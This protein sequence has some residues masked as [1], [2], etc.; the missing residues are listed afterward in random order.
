MGDIILV[1]SYYYGSYAGQTWAAGA[2][3]HGAGCAVPNGGRSDDAAD[4]HHR[5]RDAERRRRQHA[6][7]GD[8]CHR[9]NSDHNPYVRITVSINS[10][11]KSSGHDG[12]NRPGLRGGD[13]GGAPEMGRHH[14][15]L[16]LHHQDRWQR[17]VRREELAGGEGDLDAGCVLSQ[18]TPTQFETSSVSP[19]VSTTGTQ[20]VTPTVTGP[21]G[22]VTVTQTVTPGTSVLHTKIG[23]DDTGVLGGRPACFRTPARTCPS[24]PHWGC[25]SCCSWRGERGAFQGGHGAQPSALNL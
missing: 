14:P 12:H 22:T 5:D 9:T 4:D 7:E 20:T 13:E 23:T 8:L 24:A 21:N 10:V 6:P 3:I 19:T 15:E 11:I 25:P 2:A 1:F 18:P 17:V 16:H